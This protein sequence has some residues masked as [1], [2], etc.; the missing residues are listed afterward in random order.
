MSHILPPFTCY[1]DLLLVA[2]LGF[3]ALM[4]PQLERLTNEA[5]NIFHMEWVRL[6]WVGAERKDQPRRQHLVLERII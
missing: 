6:R 5:L 2:S 1:L 4:L 3:F